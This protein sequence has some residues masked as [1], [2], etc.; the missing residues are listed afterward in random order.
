MKHFNKHIF[1]CTNNREKDDQSCGNSGALELLKYAKD[2][3]S[4]L[5][6]KEKGLRIN[7]AG[8][9]GNCKFGPVV[10]I[11]PEGVWHTCQTTED[12]DRLLASIS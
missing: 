2:Q 3:A 8:C 5:N 12:I 6:F 4:R 10:V 9:L 1:I 11:Y 7:S